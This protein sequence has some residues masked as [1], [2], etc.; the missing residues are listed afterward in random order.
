METVGIIAVAIIGFGLISQR[1]QRGG[2]TP[3][4]VFLL[5]GILVG[6][7]ALGLVDADLESGW[8]HL[9][10]E[11]ALIMV[12]FTDASRIDLRLL[13]RGHDLPIPLSSGYR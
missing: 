6:P 4:M 2:V 3:P 12:L 8:V 9:L 10:A 1:V 11:L 13:R 5:F 7:R